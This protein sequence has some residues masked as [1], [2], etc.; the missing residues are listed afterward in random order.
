MKKILVTL[1]FIFY[2]QY[3]FTQVSY[4][5]CDP[6]GLYLSHG[7]VSIL[8]PGQAKTVVK[9]K[10]M[11]FIQER[12]YVYKP[13]YSTESLVAFR[14]FVKCV[15]KSEC[16]ADLIAKNIFRLTYDSGYVKIQLQY[17]LYSSF[18]G[19]ELLINENDDVASKRDIPFAPYEFQ[20][21]EQ[22]SAEYPEAMYTFSKKGKI[23]IKNPGVRQTILSFY[24][25]YITDM[26]SWFRENH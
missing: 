14:D 12:N 9:Q 6:N 15:D 17:E 21:P 16:G 23:K 13:F 10:I 8:L 2:M 26:E 4:F 19:A 11:S 1:F 25:R 22:Y 18:Y 5:T 24:N 3:G 7:S 20:V